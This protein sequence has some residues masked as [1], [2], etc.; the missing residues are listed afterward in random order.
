MMLLQRHGQHELSMPRKTGIHLS[1]IL[2]E[3]EVNA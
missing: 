1:C 3:C 2:Q